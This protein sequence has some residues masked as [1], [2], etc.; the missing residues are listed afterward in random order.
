M[1]FGSCDIADICIEEIAYRAAAVYW[2]MHNLFKGS[3]I[4]E[5]QIVYYLVAWWECN[6]HINIYTHICI[7]V[8]IC[9]YIYTHIH[10]HI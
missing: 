7:Y 5:F 10:I 1:V 6:V 2:L 4:Q 9:S 3:E 8:Y